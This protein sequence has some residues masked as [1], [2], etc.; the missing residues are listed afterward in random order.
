MPDLPGC[1]PPGYEDAESLGLPQAEMVI[2]M[3][4]T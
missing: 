4:R 2:K 3:R 1:E